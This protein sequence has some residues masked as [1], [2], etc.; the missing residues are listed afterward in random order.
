MK[1]RKNTS[2]DSSSSKKIRHETKANE[3]ILPFPIL[4]DGKTLWSRANHADR[5]RIEKMYKSKKDVEGVRIS[6]DRLKRLGDNIG[7]VMLQYYM[8]EQKVN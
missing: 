2:E 6:I 3:S 1:K 5:K 7:A 8:N 4:L